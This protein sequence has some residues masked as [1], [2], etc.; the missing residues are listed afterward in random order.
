M[1]AVAGHVAEAHARGAPTLALVLIAG[2]RAHQAPLDFATHV[3]ICY[4][5]G[6]AGVPGAWDQGSTGLNLTAA[7]VQGRACMVLF[8]AG[9]EINAIR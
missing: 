1:K 9:S 8:L 6:P 5:R 7:E 2:L 4:E 3:P